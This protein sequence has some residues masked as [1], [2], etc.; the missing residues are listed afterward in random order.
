[1]K[2]LNKNK[3]HSRADFEKLAQS[4]NIPPELDDFERDALEGWKT[5]AASFDLLKK[6]DKR[7]LKQKTYLWMAAVLVP[8]FVLIYIGVNFNSGNTPKTGKKSSQIK[9]AYI[10]KTDVE[11]PAKIEDLKPIAQKKI[12]LAK[13]LQQNFQDKNETQQRETSAVNEENPEIELET[14][15]AEEIRDNLPVKT[16]RHN[17]KA[18]EM[19][20]NDLLIVDYR[21]YRFKPAIKTEQA[22]ITGTPANMESQEDEV[23]EMQWEQVN[24]PYVEY[25]SKTMGIFARGNYKKALTRYLE[26]LDTYPDDLNASFYGALC[27]Y[28]LGEFD[29]AY[30]LFTS[31]K[32]HKFNNFTEESAWYGAKSLISMKETDKAKMQL[33]EI[34]SNKG[35]YA[36]K[37][38]IELEK[39][40]K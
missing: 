29:R 31:C 16:E 7:F 26:I 28:N 23:E 33:E 1:M 6:T 25:I 40:K 18:A 35:F 17:L 27:Y 8:V 22:I 36:E 21:K 39:L 24:I 14:K 13:T 3:I 10:E 20:V 9:R 12:I 34:I 15:K 11:T 32:I 2:N 37:A 38:R 5:N 19:Y 4:G 30:Q